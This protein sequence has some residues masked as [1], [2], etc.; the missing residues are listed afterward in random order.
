MIIE[1][2]QYHSG[3]K[4]D[5][6]Y[7]YHELSPLI[8]P[9]LEELEVK[10]GMEE[11]RIVE[12]GC[13]SHPLISSADSFVM[14]GKTKKCLGI[15]ISETIIDKLREELSSSS[16]SRGGSLKYIVGDVSNELSQ[17]SRNHFS[18]SVLQEDDE[19][20]RKQG[21]ERE[22]EEEEG[23][24]DVRLSSCSPHLIID[25]GTLDCLI[26]NT[27]EEQNEDQNEMEESQF[28][29]YTS[30]LFQT[31]FPLRLNDEEDKEDDHHPRT[32]FLVTHLNPFDHDVMFNE[33]FEGLSPMDE[34]N[35]SLK[36]DFYGQFN[37]HEESEEHEGSEVQEND[38]DGQQDENSSPPP[39]CVCAVKY[40]YFENMVNKEDWDIDVHFY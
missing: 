1:C 3:Y 16:S 24:K 14:E 8:D 9:I 28:L 22:G 2:F 34:L 39:P 5:W 31:F 36:V 37:E 7:S 17:I 13:G 19:D 15:D 32:F 6:Y 12:C 30:Q 40:L 23:G 10:D 38:D 11:I 21:D 27:E 29:K 18:P 26:S 35:H 20:K 33:L 4:W 25:K